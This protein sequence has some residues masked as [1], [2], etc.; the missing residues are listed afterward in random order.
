MR[1]FQTIGFAEEIQPNTFVSPGMR[2]VNGRGEL[3]LDWP[4]PQEIGPDGWHASYRF[5]QPDL[6]RS[7]RKG[8]TRFDA[9]EVRLRCDVFALDEAADHVVLRYE[10]LATGA[11]EQATARYVIGCDGARSVVR[12]F[13]GAPVE[14]LRSHERWLIVDLL[15]KQPRPDLPSVTVQ[16]CDPARPLTMTPCTANAAAGNSCSCPATT[17]Q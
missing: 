9:V 1:V 4:R 16:Y 5:H 13:M 14:D 10:N 12:R 7:L 17:R 6:G 15:L 8:V 2:F 11:L 3:L